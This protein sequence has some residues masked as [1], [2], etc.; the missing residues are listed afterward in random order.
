MIP[1]EPTR[2][3]DVTPS[4]AAII[5]SGLELATLAMLWCSASQYRWYP[6]A[7]ATRASSSVS[8]NAREGLV[9]EGT[10]D[11]SSTD[12]GMASL[13]TSPPTTSSHRLFHPTCPKVRRLL[14]GHEIPLCAPTSHFREEQGKG[15]A[16]W[17]RGYAG[18]GVRARAS[19]RGRDHQASWVR[20]A[21]AAGAVAGSRGA[22]AEVKSDSWKPRV[23]RMGTAWRSEEHTSELQSH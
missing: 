6:D 5:T 12:K 22:P 16:L 23:S 11:R 4:T 1:P 20:R 18:Y 14:F 13:V 7:S 8:R 3:V 9:P 17:A 15:A 19:R 2:I 10:G 21:W